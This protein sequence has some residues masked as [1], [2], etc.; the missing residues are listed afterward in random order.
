M[1]QVLT[2]PMAYRNF[3]PELH[4]KNE[5]PHLVV[6]NYIRSLNELTSLR[7]GKEVD[8]FAENLHEAVTTLQAT[9]YGHELN[10]SVELAII[11]H[12]LPPLIS[13]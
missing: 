8:E 13:H 2:S 6:R 11:I 3:L 5:H 4:R 10:S 1:S 9:V 7:E 12:K